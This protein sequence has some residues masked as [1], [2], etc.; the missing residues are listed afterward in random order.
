MAAQSINKSQLLSKEAINEVYHKYAGILYGI[1]CR[2]APNEPLASE[3]LTTAFLNSF[4]EVNA[5]RQC[6]VHLAQL[7]AAIFENAVSVLCTYFSAEEMAMKIQLEQERFLNP[8]RHNF[9]G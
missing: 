7:L 4:Q 5:N 6:R 2:L 3:I 9:S 1:A 8:L